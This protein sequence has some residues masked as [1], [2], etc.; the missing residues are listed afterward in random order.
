MEG[1]KQAGKQGLC[2][3]SHQFDSQNWSL[4]I[5]ELWSGEF[6][7]DVI[8]A[9][10]CCEAVSTSRSGI[11]VF[12]D[13]SFTSA[14]LRLVILCVRSKFFSTSATFAVRLFMCSTEY[15][16][17]HWTKWGHLLTLHSFHCKKLFKTHCVRFSFLLCK[18]FYADFFG[19]RP[20]FHEAQILERRPNFWAPKYGAQIWAPWGPKKN[21]AV[22]FYHW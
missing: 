18:I 10:Y 21:T 7:S 1:A 15:I 6:P 16:R 20:N 3:H 22:R 12:S 8:S 5:I 14:S 17:R 2:F 4:L 9:K 11:N 13:L 19:L